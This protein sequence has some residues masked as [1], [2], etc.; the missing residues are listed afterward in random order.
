M[1]MNSHSER[2]LD[3]TVFE[4]HGKYYCVWAEK[5]SVGKQISNLYIAEMETA[6]RLRTVQVLLTS[7]DYDWERIGF[8]VNEGPAVMKRTRENFFDV[9]CK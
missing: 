5:V 6:N 7:P 9:F 2:F 1:K 3:A 8:W 4:N